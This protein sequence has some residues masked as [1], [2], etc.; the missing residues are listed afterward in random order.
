MSMDERAQAWGLEAAQAL[1][2]DPARVF[3]TLLVSHEKSLAVVVIP[4]ASRL[5]LKAIAK[6]LGWKKAQLADPALAQRT[7]GYVVGGISPLGQKKALPTLI[8]ASAPRMRRCLSPAGGADWI[9]S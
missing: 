8:D 1:G 7:T 4:V 9:W 6:Q 2:L 5:D 3:K